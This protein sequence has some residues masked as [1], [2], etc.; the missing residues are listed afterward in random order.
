MYIADRYR[1]SLAYRVRKQYLAAFGVDQRQM[2]RRTY[3]HGQHERDNSR[4]N[5]DYACGRAPFYA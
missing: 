3:K 4:N 5:Y 2:Q 1:F